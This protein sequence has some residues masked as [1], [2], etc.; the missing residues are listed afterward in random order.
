ILKALRGYIAR[1]SLTPEQVKWLPFAEQ[2]FA[3]A[4]PTN[5]DWQWGLLN[6]YWQSAELTTNPVRQMAL[7]LAM[8]HT[9]MRERNL[10]ATQSD[11]LARAEALWA[12]ARQR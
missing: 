5:E 10:T 11:W 8:A 12:Q 3:A 2:A 1:N 6:M 9:I 7:V 4:N